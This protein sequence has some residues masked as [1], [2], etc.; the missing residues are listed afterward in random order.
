[1]AGE[2]GM[3]TPMHRFTWEIHCNY[4]QQELDPAAQGNLNKDVM[5]RI[6]V[7]PNDARVF[8]QRSDGV[9][10][11]FMGDYLATIFDKHERSGGD[12]G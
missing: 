3:V 6:Y 7:C 1:M 9:L 10:N 12:G 5:F 8:V 4:C 2:D 11:T